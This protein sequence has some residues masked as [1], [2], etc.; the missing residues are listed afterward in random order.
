MGP[1]QGAG[2]SQR[3]FAESGG[4]SAVT[5]FSNALPSHTH[6]FAASSGEQTSNRPGGTVPARG[7]A[8]GIPDGT[9]A[10]AGAVE[11]AGE[12]QP[13]DNMPPYLVLSFCVSLSGIFPSQS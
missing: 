6:A 12:T 3:Q 2:L 9:L 5:L 11:S 13:H 8:Y 4:I 1:G 10:E 7:G